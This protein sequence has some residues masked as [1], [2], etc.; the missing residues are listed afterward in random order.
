MLSGI[1]RFNTCSLL[2]AVLALGCTCAHGQSVNPAEDEFRLTVQAFSLTAE[3]EQLDGRMPI[4]EL[5]QQL[6]LE[7]ARFG[8]SMSVDDLHQVGDALTL[9]LRN[10][11]FVFHTV[12]LPPQK[13]EGGLVELRLQEGVLGSVHVINNS[14]LADK[15]FAKVFSGQKGE[16][17]Y[18]P[19]VEDKVQ[20]LKA[21][22]GF[23]VFP[24]YSRGAGPG[25]ARLNLR[26]DKAPQRSFSLK[27]DNYGS[28]VSGEHRAILQYSEYQLTGHHDRL[29]L[30]VLH[31][32]DDVANTYGSISYTLP[33]AGLDYAWDISASNNQFEIGDRLAHLGLK[34]D[35]STVRTG[36]SHIFKH[37]SKHRSTLRLGAYEKRNNLDAGDSGAAAQEEISRAVS[38]AWSKDKQW[39]SSSSAL[40]FF[41]EISHGEYETGVLPDGEFNKLDLSGF[42]VKGMASGHLRN[43]FQLSFRGQYSD[44][45]LPSIEGFSLTGPYG[46]RGYEPGG[47]SADSAVI[48]S[49]EWRLPGLLVFSADQ[50]WRLEPYL[51]GDWATGTKTSI[52][53]DGSEKELEATYSSAGVGLRMS[54]GRH[55]SAQVTASKALD[56]ENNG[57]KVE[58]DEQILFEIRLH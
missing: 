37:H 50:R 26:V 17:L 40:S 55:V 9:Y 3:P 53:I 14:K 32:L 48:A 18:G 7:R 4:A 57:Q 31:S 21:Q 8:E 15:R 28:A 6:L 41:G 20:A 43:I 47:F 27:L 49:A 13:V 39:S 51:V 35:A 46:V 44:A 23:D 29:S 19:T 2:A 58:G 25:E 10:K 12:Y 11:G 22:G 5:E 30:A 33:F 45:L 52:E 42:A 24:F 36:I 56:G 38:L 54:I 34:G 1:S 16:V